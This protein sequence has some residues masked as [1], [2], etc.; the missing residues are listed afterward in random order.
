MEKNSMANIVYVKQRLN[1]SFTEIFSKIKE[2]NM[3]TEFSFDNLRTMVWR[4][5]RLVRDYH[6][7]LANSEDKD[8]GMR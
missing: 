2:I 6:I 3:D 7:A 4:M 1:P 5:D 8:N